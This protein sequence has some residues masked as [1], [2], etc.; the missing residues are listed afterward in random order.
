MNILYNRILD[1]FFSFTIPIPI[2][3]FSVLYNYLFI[4]LLPCSL[5]DWT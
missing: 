5:K 3:N 4:Y 2:F 1:E